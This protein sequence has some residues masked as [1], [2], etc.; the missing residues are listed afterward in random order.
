MIPR[1]SGESA[2]MGESE[3]RDIQE[4][5]K[6]RS[7]NHRQRLKQFGKWEQSQIHHKTPTKVVWVHDK[8]LLSHSIVPMP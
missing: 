5:S 3:G 4:A 6:T 1:S 2:N 8:W 7:I